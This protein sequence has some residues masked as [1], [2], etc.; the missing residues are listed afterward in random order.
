MENNF[1]DFSKWRYDNLILKPGLNEFTFFDTRPNVFFIINNNKTYLY[2][3]LDN[4]PDDNK[5]EHIVRPNATNIVGRP[6]PMSHIYFFNPKQNNINIKLYSDYTEFDIGLLKTIFAHIDDDDLNKIKYDGVITGWQTTDV[7]NVFV[8]N[9]DDIYGNIVNSCDSIH[10]LIGEFKKIVIEKIIDSAEQSNQLL[11]NINNSIGNIKLS[12]IEHNINN[13]SNYYVSGIAKMN[14]MIDLLQNIINKMNNSNPGSGSG[15]GS[16]SGNTNITKNIDLNKYN[17]FKLIY[18]TNKFGTLKSLKINISDIDDSYGE[19]IFYIINNEQLYKMSLNDINNND[20]KYL[21][22]G[23]FA[24]WVLSPEYITGYNANIPVETSKSLECIIS[25]D[26]LLY[27]Q[28]PN[29]TITQ[30]SA[31]RGTSVTTSIPLTSIENKYACI[32]FQECI[33]FD[34]TKYEYGDIRLNCPNFSVIN[35]SISSDQIVYAVFRKL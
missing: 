15:S 20:L 9:P 8:T 14:T 13:N 10:D 30:Y 25:F 33:F 16:G 29:Y 22:S 11:S 35:N 1:R 34:N 4:L 27:E 31:N 12:S 18:E 7:V 5:Y 26:K 21:E 24:I 28:S 6:L 19:P 3:G 23:F 17:N 2:V 32:T